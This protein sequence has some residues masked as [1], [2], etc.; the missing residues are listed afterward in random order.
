MAPF[1]TSEWRTTS[2]HKGSPFS[3]ELLVLAAQAGEQW[4]FVELCFR[5]SRRVIF[6][7]SKIT[8]NRED[9]EDLFQESILKAFVH[10]GN[11]NRASSF[12]TWLTRISMN[13][14]LMML[15][16]KRVR[17][18]V[19]TDG[20]VDQN[21]KPFLWELAD[22][23]PSPEEQLIKSES[24]KRLQLAI[25][26]LPTSYRTVVEIRHRS[27]A[28]LKEIAEETGITVAATKSRLLRGRNALRKSLW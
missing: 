1:G 20:S 14:A 26:R 11:F 19:S 18:E 6:T 3:D 16:R 7:L 25:S 23:R 5:H 4:A 24:Q 27:D 22:R 28:S 17:P 15:R 13:S 21:A 12:S 9:A 8:R 2:A 10:L